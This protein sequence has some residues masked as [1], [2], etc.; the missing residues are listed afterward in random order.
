[1]C[2]VCDNKRLAEKTAAT[3]PSNRNA[4]HFIEGNLILPAV[5]KLRGSLALVVGDV[6]PSFQR[7]AIN[8][9]SVSEVVFQ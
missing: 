6:L 9:S 4:L 8:P 2:C 3:T 1:M 5:V 7:T